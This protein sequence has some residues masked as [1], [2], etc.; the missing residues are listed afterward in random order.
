MSL[1]SASTSDSTASSAGFQGGSPTR[2]LR[3]LIA[4]RTLILNAAGFVTEAATAV[5]LIKLNL[6]KTVLACDHR[7]GR[8]TS[9]AFILANLIAAPGT[10]VN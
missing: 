3:S 8:N 2:T 9:L 5:G 10:L 7:V 6:A 4:F 1:F